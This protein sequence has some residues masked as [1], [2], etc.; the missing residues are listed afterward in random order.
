MSAKSTAAASKITPTEL[1]SWRSMLDTTMALR[2]QL[3]AVITDASGLSEPDF[4]VLL[5]LIEAE[6]KPL[7]A[8]DLAE[9]IG[10]DRS[11]LSHQLNRME[12]RGLIAR[13]ACKEDNRGTELLITDDGRNLMREATGPHFAA[14][15]E[16]F[17][18]TLSPA[19]ID[20]LAK[21]TGKLAAKVGTQKLC[22]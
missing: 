9:Q 15:K 16:L 7:R 11:R 1:A 14:L 5:A 8:S 12:T 2:R 13:T 21:I 22:D 10:W 4:V 19:E 20:Q 17:A 18:N 3:Q 6:G